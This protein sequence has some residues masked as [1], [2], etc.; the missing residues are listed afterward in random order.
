MKINGTFVLRDI[1]DDHVLVPVGST[2]VDFGGLVI[3]NE[4]GAMLWK[5]MEKDGEADPERLADALCDEY[6][7]DRETAL[8][9]VGE[10]LRY[11]EDN[12][13]LGQ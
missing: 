3:L 13:V 7:C 5:V 8:A 11:L 6:D 1:V 10:F 4:S 9:D 2:S 12:D